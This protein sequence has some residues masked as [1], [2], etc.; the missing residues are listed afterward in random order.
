M[1]KK[2]VRVLNS[3]FKNIKIV[4]SKRSFEFN[5]AWLFAILV[6][7]IILFLAIYFAVR[8]VGTGTYQVSTITMKQ[9]SII[10]EPLEVGL[11][12]GK[13]SLAVLKEETRIYDK[14]EEQGNFGKQKFSG[15][16]KI[17]GNKWSK[18]GAEI[19][20]PNKYIFSNGTEQGK[21]VYFFSKPF[22]MPWK[23]SEI[24]FLTTEKYCFVNAPEFVVDEVSGLNL[25]NIRFENCSNEI[26]VC[27]S[28]SGCEIEV[29]PSCLQDC[30]EQ[31]EYSYG[32]VNKKGENMFFVG[33]LMY[34]GIFSN[35]DIYECNVKRLM[36]RLEKQALLFNN[37]INFLTG[38][39]GNP[40]NFIQLSSL[41]RSLKSSRD[42]LL[43]Y[44]IA[45]EVEKQN[46]AS[47]CKLW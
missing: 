29:S 11:A 8:W 28:S 20:V 36:K 39:C 27:F 14:C 38:K 31:E 15:A 46:E 12:S 10:F 1:D 42:L 13:S 41:A 9:L 6:G 16:G 33:S 34:A 35:K 7:A 5:F 37:E 18:P 24:I 26:K 43:V 25:G 3:K 44:N 22:E 47:E 4:N 17:F 21:I 19:S 40:S 45:K 2:A 23:V 30:D 32:F